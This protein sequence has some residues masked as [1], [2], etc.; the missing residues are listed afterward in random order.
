MD[1]GTHV[2]DLVRWFL[3]E[4]SLASGM[5]QTAFWPIAPLE[6][7]AFALLRTDD[8]RT[9]SIH[10]SWTQWKPL[11]SLELFGTE[12]YALA[13]GLGG[14]YGDER[15]V[16]GQRDF[17]APFAEQVVEFRGEDRS[18]SAEIK[19]FLSAIAENREPL[20]SGQDGLEA[21]RLV[22]AVYTAARTGRTVEL[23]GMA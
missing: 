10:V 8:G 20:A 13:D 16:L 3:G 5:A 23:Q 7:N 12:G 22:E 4:V 2:L 19:E 9:A 6:D 17:M 15:A 21:L 14:A 11:F 1:Q 18:W